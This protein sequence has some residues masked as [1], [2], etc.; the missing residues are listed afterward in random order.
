MISGLLG[1]ES[2]AEMPAA[3]FG[4]FTRSPTLAG[5]AGEQEAISNVS[6]QDR[7]EAIDFVNRLNFA[8]DH[9]NIAETLCGKPSS[10]DLPIPESTARRV[11]VEPVAV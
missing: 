7:V 10:L 1:G 6:A 4:G 2:P 11:A 3:Q 9:W 5:E 8:F